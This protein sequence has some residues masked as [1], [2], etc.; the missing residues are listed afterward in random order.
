MDHRGRLRSASWL[1]SAAAFF[2]LTSS[3][4]AQGLLGMGLPGLPFFGDSSGEPLSCA[5][6]KSVC[7]PL[8]FYAGGE[9]TEEAPRFHLTFD[10]LTLALSLTTCC[11]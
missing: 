6:T 7:G 3:V 11:L 9:R 8:T 2:I 4:G 10:A 5:P 1:L